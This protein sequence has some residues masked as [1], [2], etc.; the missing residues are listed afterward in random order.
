MVSPPIGCRERELV[1]ISTPRFDLTIKGNPCHPKTGSP[2]RHDEKKQAN[3][4]L[5]CSDRYRLETYSKQKDRLQQHD[6]EFVASVPVSPLFYEEQNY[7]IIIENKSGQQISFWHENKNLQ[8]KVGYVG[9]SKKVLTGVINF[10]SE[11]GF[12]EFKILCNG[13]VYLEF[14]LEVFPSKLDYHQDYLALLT[15]VNNEL[16]NLAFDFLKKTYLWS[17][18]SENRGGSLTEFF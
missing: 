14:T 5:K 15:D 1:Y 7:E 9:K 8:E 12:S 18:L 11:I 13:S 6:C 17:R 4:T 10:G 2:D 16:Y 3:L